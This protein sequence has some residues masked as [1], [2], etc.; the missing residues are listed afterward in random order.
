MFGDCNT[1]NVAS[2]LNFVSELFRDVLRPMF[3]RVERNDANRVAVLAGH[4]IVDDGFVVGLI[5]IGFRKCRAEVSVIVD[6]EIKILIVTVRHNRGDKALVHKNSYR[7]RHEEFEHE[8]EASESQSITAAVL[9]M[10]S[11]ERFGAGFSIGACAMSASVI[12]A[13]RTTSEIR[14]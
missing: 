12:A 9:A 14:V 8:I 10:M 7:N 4:K 2:G 13:R 1:F 6:D 11:G 3:Q 5:D